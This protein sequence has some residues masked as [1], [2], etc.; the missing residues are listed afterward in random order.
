MADA[1]AELEILI[2]IQAAI[3]SLDSLKAEAKEAAKAAKEIQTA[4]E[5]MSA[6][7]TKAFGALKTAAV[8]A[9]GVLAGRAVVGF[10]KDGV[11]A[12]IA[13]ENAMSRLA[14]ALSLTGENS[15]AALAGFKAFAD[16]LEKTTNIADDV[17]LSQLALAKSF[18]LTN[19]EAQNLVAAA[20][21]LSA[22]TGDDLETSVRNLGKTFAGVTGKLDEQV[23]ALK[24]LTKAQLANGDAIAIV[25][26]RYKGS[27]AKALDTYAGALKAAENA[28]GNFQEAIGEAIVSNPQLIQ[29]FKEISQAFDDLTASVEGAGLQET[30]TTVVN[31]VSAALSALAEFAAGVGIIL[32]TAIEVASRAFSGIL[33]LAEGFADNFTI[34]FRAIDGVINTTLEA[35]KLVID[36]SGSIGTLFDVDTTNLEGYSKKIDDLKTNITGVYSQNVV[37]GIAGINDSFV[38]FAVGVETSVGDGI[39]ALQDFSIGVEASALRIAD[40]AQKG[41]EA[42]TKAAAEESKKREGIY[43]KETEAAEKA[44]KAAFDAEKKANDKREQ[45]YADSTAA[46]TRSIKEVSEADLKAIASI[47]DAAQKEIDDAGKAAADAAKDLREDI[48]SIASNP[49]A[50][51][52]TSNVEALDLDPASQ[53]LAAGIAGGI[54]A[55]LNGKEGAKSL[56]SGAAGA[57]ADALIPGL[58]PA[59]TSIVGKLA[60]G[61]EATKAFIR[62]FVAAVPD[63]VEAIGESAPALVEALVDSLINEGGAVRIGIAIAKAMAGEGVWKSIGK[64]IGLEFGSAFNSSNIAQT[65]K[66]AFA[67]GAVSLREFPRALQKFLTD[68]QNAAFRA[69]QAI[70]SAIKGFPAQIAGAFAEGGR[71]AVAALGEFFGG[72]G[73]TIKTA[74]DEAVTNLAIPIPGWLIDFGTA[75]DNLTTTPA[76][77]QPFID[78]VNSLVGAEN[79]LSPGG[80]GGGVG[81]TLI[82]TQEAILTGGASEVP[83]LEEA[84][85]FGLTGGGDADTAAILSLLGSILDAVS[86]PQTAK[87]TVQFNSKTLA[88]IILQLNRNGARLTA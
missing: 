69:G 38:D 12:A 25:A 50:F 39:T 4:S 71:E 81:G 22:A 15:E 59:I 31:A 7:A 42:T 57:F 35:L 77:I 84:V 53:K 30:V 75:V 70:A 8:A 19:Q 29:L 83:G 79:P 14:Q 3:K 73:A 78:A 20:V 64:Q 32:Q 2:Q 76:W 24:A 11:D 61:P 87:A 5:K 51:T 6:G 43:K 66:G 1:T 60:E 34:V 74:F 17:V 82:R 44:A 27:A 58:G 67:A 46:V 26:K 36:T 88:D 56:I 45:D 40:G 85:G 47:G 41:F 10:F 68:F 72:I 21:D 23:P 54:D 62:E 55:A 80:S 37:D 18:G 33:T 49:I 16:N 65:I 28:F 48:E 9:I 52:I 13:Q 86:T 63:I